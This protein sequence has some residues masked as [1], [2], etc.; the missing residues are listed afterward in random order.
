MINKISAR[1]EVSLASR[2]T[3]ATYRKLADVKEDF[4]WM[5]KT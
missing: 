3:S 5:L 4:A 2:A 1:C